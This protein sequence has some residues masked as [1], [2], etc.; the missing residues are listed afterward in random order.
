MPEDTLKSGQKWLFWISKENSYCAQIEINELSVATGRP[1][2]LRPCF[3]VDVDL[4]LN[5][6]TWKLLLENFVLDFFKL[7]NGQPLKMVNTLKQFIG[8]LPAN[9][10]CFTILWVF[11]ADIQ[12]A[13]E[14]SKCNEI[15]S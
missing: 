10:L 1:L 9:S 14:V 2:L 12:P 3:A 11:L 13:I 7:F 6:L 5:E 4:F 8:N 15:T